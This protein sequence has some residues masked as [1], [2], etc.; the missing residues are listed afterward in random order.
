MNNYIPL[1]KQ[2][3]LFVSMMVVNLLLTKNLV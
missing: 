1:K 3:F 2:L